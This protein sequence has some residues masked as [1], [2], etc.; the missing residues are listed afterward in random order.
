[1]NAQ[2]TAKLHLPLSLFHFRLELREL[3]DL[4]A[5]RPIPL[6]TYPATQ[7]EQGLEPSAELSTLGRI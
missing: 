1:M 3:I 2:W 5:L 4:Q 7:S 6:R